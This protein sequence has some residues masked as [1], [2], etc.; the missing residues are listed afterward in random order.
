[1]RQPNVTFSANDNAPPRP[2]RNSPVLKPVRFMRPERSIPRA[3]KTNVMAEY[4]RNTALSW[5]IPLLG[6]VMAIFAVLQGT[7]LSS[8]VWPSMIMSLLL[9]WIATRAEAHS[10]LQNLSALML[11]GAATICAAG[12]LSENGFTLVGVEL[13]LLVSVFSLL[14]G[15]AISSRPVVMLSTISAIVYLMSLF[16][17]LGLLTGITEEFSQ[18]GIALIP[19]LLLGQTLLAQRLKSHSITVLTIFAVLIW[20][21]AIAKD[22]PLHALAGLCFAVAAAHYCLGRACETANIFGARLHTFFALIVGLATALYIQS[23]WMQFDSDKAQPVWSAST[24]WWSAV[25]LSM[26]VILIT[27]LIRFK[28]SQISLLGIFIITLG[29]LVLP[30]ATAKPELIETTFH[31]IPGLDAYPGLGLVIGAVIIASCL[32]WIAN[33]LKRGRLLNVLIGTIAIGV[34][35]IIL[36]QPDH[37]NLDFAV[38]FVMSLICALC[39]GGLIAGSTSN[40][41]ESAANYA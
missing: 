11:V 16:P 28:S 7:T 39:I 6:G 12:T 36:Y 1:M 37:F 41:T 18:I 21:L 33:G 38:I 20:V 23:L 25:V 13:A 29:I 22:L 31:R 14:I 4:K 3:T 5:G 8:L 15:W 40:H 35:A 32:I 26:S 34:E 17:E 2:R 27:S 19:G 9:L 30:L 10:R 24:F